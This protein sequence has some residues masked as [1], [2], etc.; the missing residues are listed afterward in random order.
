MYILDRM[1]QRS[2]RIKNVSLVASI[3]YYRIYRYYILSYLYT[4]V[5][6][7]TLFTELFN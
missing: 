2:N 5:F 3:I 4:I 1:K 6:I 7:D